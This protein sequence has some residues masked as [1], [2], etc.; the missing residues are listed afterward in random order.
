M[1]RR[2]FDEA[3]KEFLKALGIESPADLTPGQFDNAMADILVDAIVKLKEIDR[4]YVNRRP[5][6]TAAEV[7]KDAMDCMKVWT[8]VLEKVQLLNR[9]I[10]FDGHSP[11]PLFMLFHAL[12]EVQQKRPSMLLSHNIPKET[13]SG[14]I[15]IQNNHILVSI[16]AIAAATLQVLFENGLP[17]E[18]AAEQVSDAL[19]RCGV[20]SPKKSGEPYAVATVIH[21]RK[22]ARN[23]NRPFPEQFHAHLNTFRR[24][25]AEQSRVLVPN[26]KG[27][28][29]LYQ[30]LLELMNDLVESLTYQP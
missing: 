13:P 26:G 1:D 16:R 20:V 30:D 24:W 14:R 22:K 9:E 6:R 18:E 8:R 23:L 27:I 4:V 7:R 5:K 17:L 10:L 2:P 25:F 19:F 15:G 12:D 11:M 29:S 28:E 3:S 21:W